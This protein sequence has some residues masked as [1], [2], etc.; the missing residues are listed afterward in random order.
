MI[1]FSFVQLVSSLDFLPFDFN[2]FDFI[3]SSSLK[4]RAASLEFK[5]PSSS[6]Y[7]KGLNSSGE[8]A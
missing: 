2:S 4:I 8:K 3:K 6:D 5:V 1:G 7:R